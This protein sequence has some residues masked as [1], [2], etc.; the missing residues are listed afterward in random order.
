MHRNI[1]LA[2]VLMS[3]FGF[4]LLVEAVGV[5]LR[6]GRLDAQHFAVH[7]L[8][9]ILWA[10]VVWAL[11]LGRR[12]A[13]LTVVTYGSL[14]G[15][16]AVAALLT[17]LSAGVPLPALARAAAEGLRLG[18]GGILLGVASIA[19]LVAGVGLLLTKPARQAF[20]PTARKEASGKVSEA[21]H[22]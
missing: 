5:A 19:T 12:W 1:K 8:G 4:F 20:L 17:A 3:F 16:L 14:M 13:W 15:A 10:L 11:L 7:L 9:A 18:P 22:G 6:E 21:G 2:A